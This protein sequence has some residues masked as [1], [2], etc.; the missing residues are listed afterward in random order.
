M[1]ALANSFSKL[2]NDMVLTEENVEI[3]RFENGLFKMVGPGWS[4]RDDV[5]IKTGL[6]EDSESF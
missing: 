5:Y 4:W 3:S 2:T 6:I 1:N